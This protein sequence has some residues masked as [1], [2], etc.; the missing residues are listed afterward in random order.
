LWTD[1]TQ[2][3]FVKVD[4]DQLAQQRR[5]PVVVSAFTVDRCMACHH[6]GLTNPTDPAP[7][8]SN[9]I[10]RR[11]ASDA[12]RYSPGLRA[13]QGNWT[14]ARLVEFLSDPAKF[15]NGTNMPN[16]GLD[17]EQLKDIV[18]TLVR[19]SGPPPAPAAQR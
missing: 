15:A 4:T 7:S 16:L 13:K 8:L 5:Y 11:I 17:R 18:D 6:L 19:A 1:D 2:L 14:E 12:F 9:L 10:N 3:L